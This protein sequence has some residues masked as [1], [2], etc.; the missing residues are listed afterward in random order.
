MSIDC[1][2]IT[3][4]SKTWIKSGWTGET[5]RQLQTDLK[6]LG[7]YLT[8]NGS[9]L[10]TDGKFQ[11]WT[12]VAVKAFQKS[13]GNTQDGKV[14]PKTCKSFNEQ[15]TK[16]TAKNE[17]VVGLDCTTVRL[18]P[19]GANNNEDDVKLLQTHLKTLGYYTKVNGKELKIDGD[20]GPYTQQA[21]KAFQRATGNSEDAIFGP[22]TC[23]S[24]NQA[25]GATKTTATV[26][27]ETKQVEDKNKE[28]IIEA[29]KY[30]FLPSTMKGNFHI[31]GVHFISS[32]VEPT[33][34]HTRGNWQT[35][36]MINNGIYT[37]EGHP[38]PIEF[39]VT[40]YIRYNDYR[41]VKPALDLMYMKP[42]SVNGTGITTGKYVVSYNIVGEYKHWWKLTFHLLQYFEGGY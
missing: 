6:K 8:A 7:F 17:E 25:I 16:I 30:Q 28:I 32:N 22:K 39:D 33:R 13:T 37:Y 9:T 21:V 15:L 27:K 40:C 35:M 38:Q 29:D 1:T 18:E 14:G 34:R 24:L 36:E 19:D 12:E 26:K 42:C 41:I 23:A 5:V 31:D 10:K 11:Y 2:K 4:D 20:Y 3:S